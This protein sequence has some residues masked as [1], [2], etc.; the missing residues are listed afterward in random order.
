MQSVWGWRSRRGRGSSGPPPLIEKEP[1]AWPWCATV[2]LVSLAVIA[3]AH[4]PSAHC[5]HDWTF[6]RLALAGA[7]VAPVLDAILIG[8]RRR[9][10]GL[11]IAVGGAA[12]VVAFAAQW[13]VILVWC[14]SAGAFD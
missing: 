10:A 7:A 1:G 9:D 11:G 4:H 13:L 3:V 12:L 5:A 6:G 2:Y 8:R 14:G